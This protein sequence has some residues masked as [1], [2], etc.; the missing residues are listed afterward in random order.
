IIPLTQPGIYVGQHVDEI[1]NE[2]LF[3]DAQG[4]SGG[5]RV[6]RFMPFVPSWSGEIAFLVGTR[7]IPE[8]VFDDVLKCDG[9]MIG[10]GRWTAKVGGMK[11]SFR[12][13][14]VTWYNESAAKEKLLEYY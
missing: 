1:Q 7:T 4:K 9:Q 3:L 10:V 14:G 5:T 13:N 8:S 2:A 11:G 6:S 12:V